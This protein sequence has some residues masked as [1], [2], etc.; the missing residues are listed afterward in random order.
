MMNVFQDI[1]KDPDI[2]LIFL[3]GIS[4]RIVF[5]VRKSKIRVSMILLIHTKEVIL[6][7]VFSGNYFSDLTKMEPLFLHQE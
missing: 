7:T 3:N 4:E 5:F 1:Q 2:F 6:S